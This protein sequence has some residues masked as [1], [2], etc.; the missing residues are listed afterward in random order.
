[1][2]N[3]C[4]EKPGQ[5]AHIDKDR[6]NND[7]DNLVWLCQPHHDKYDL[8][9]HQ[10]KGLTAHELKEYR[11]RLWKAVEEKSLTDQNEPGPVIARIGPT[12]NS[13]VGKQGTVINATGDV[14]YTV[15][16]RSKQPTISPPPNAIGSNIEMRSYIEYLNGRYIE[17][18]KIG[19]EQGLDT[20]KFYPGVMHNLASKHF[21][22]R[23]YLVPKNR[24]HNVVSFFQK[25]ID[26]TIWGKRQR[27]ANYHSFDE[28]CHQVRG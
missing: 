26:N 10:T 25:A 27:G 9:S 8:R 6:S 16:G 3:D 13:I 20:R 21:G 2:D 24:F 12:F 7:P 19:I 14:N 15:R 18:R 11:R 28:H 17:F 22:A 4:E 1:L 5:I 23:T